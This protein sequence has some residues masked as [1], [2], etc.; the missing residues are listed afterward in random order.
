VIVG[1]YKTTPNY[2]VADSRSKR[3]DALI[4]LAVIVE[5]KMLS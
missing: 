1:R 5:K 2:F 3:T 4:N